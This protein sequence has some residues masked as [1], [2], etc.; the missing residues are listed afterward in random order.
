MTR[1]AL[2][3]LLLLAFALRV[4]RLDFQ[5]LR[6]DEVFGY[7]FSLRSYDDMQQAT[8]ELQEPH[9]LASY[10]LQHWWLARVG[11]SEFALRFLSAWWST[12]AVALLYRLGWRLGLPLLSGL[13]A[14]ALLTFSPYAIWHGQDARMYSMSLALTLASVWLA[15]EWLQRQRWPW[16]SGWLAASW[17]ALHTHYFSAFVLLAQSGFM[18]S[19]AMLLPRLRFTALNWLT[20]QGVLAALYLPWLAQVSSILNQYS[21]NGDSPD[22]VAALQ[23]ALSVFAAGESTPPEQRVWWAGLALLLVVL[24]LSQLLRQGPNGR[25]TAWLLVFYLFLPLLVTWYSAQTRPIFN[26]RYLVAALPPFYLLVAS[27]L[28]LMRAEVARL[29]KP[30]HLLAWCAALGVLLLLTGSLRS[31]QRH[32]ADP[33]Y[34]KTRGWRELAAALARLAEPLPPGQVRIAQNF[35]D[36]TLWYYYAGPVAHVVLPP[37]AHDHAGAAATVAQLQTAG[38]ERIILPVQPAPNWD[39]QQIAPSALAT[40][41]HLVTEQMVGVWPVQIY[42]RPPDRLTPLAA[43]FQNGV[44]LTGFALQPPTLA[45]GAL[46][47]VQLAWQGEPAQ[48]KGTEKVFVQLLNAA[49]QLVAQQ[50]QPLTGATLATLQNPVTTYG[51]LLPDA[52]APG[53]YRL[54]AGLYDPGQDGAPRIVTQSGS[55]FVE[56]QRLRAE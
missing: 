56:L 21:G 35:P 26:E 2:L 15:A 44:S 25:R 23:R 24:G 48:L 31:L 37:A 42:A 6:G 38:V 1:T 18:L 53:S 33:H 3:L 49:D 55:D 16:I 7:F 5:E 22:L 52:L 4:Y 54:I 36:P 41:Y 46:L 40:S 39:D 30:E 32:Y 47:V 43:H 45:A 9:P 28:G 20:W 8:V 11:H 12:L 10:V 19:R 17:L 51:I 29:P 50:D 27:A 14:T 34:S 13:L